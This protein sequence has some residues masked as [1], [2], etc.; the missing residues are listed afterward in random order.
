V[1]VFRLVDPTTLGLGFP[2]RDPFDIPE[3][4]RTLICYHVYVEA[5]KLDSCLFRTH[6]QQQ[7]RRERLTRGNRGHESGTVDGLKCWDENLLARLLGSPVMY[8]VNAGSEGRFLF[9]SVNFLGAQE[10]P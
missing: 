7:S 4:E 9:L 5:V 2:T 6:R 3:F 10:G 1:F 8:R